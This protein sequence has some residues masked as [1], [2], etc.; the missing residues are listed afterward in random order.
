M[1]TFVYKICAKPVGQRNLH[2]GT[3]NIQGIMRFVV[4]TAG[5]DLLGFCIKKFTVKMCG[6]LKVY[7]GMED[8]ILQSKARIIEKLLI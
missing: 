3:A 8:R 4:I 2:K 6:L 7:A 5:E 1:D